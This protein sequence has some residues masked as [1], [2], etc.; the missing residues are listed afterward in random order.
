MSSQCHLQN[1]A[2]ASV[3]IMIALIYQPL[4]ASEQISPFH[5]QYLS[6]IY[7]PIYPSSYI[8]VY[9]RAPPAHPPPNGSAKP[10]PSPTPV[11]WGLGVDWESPFS[12]VFVGS[13]GSPSF[14]FCG[15]GSGRQESPSLLPPPCGVGSGGVDSVL[16]SLGL[17]VVVKLL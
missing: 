17:L 15:V 14:P 2:H 8:C 5:H 6:I 1:R 9:T 12:P 7:L 16:D 13:S 4:R 3:A 11:V 10:P